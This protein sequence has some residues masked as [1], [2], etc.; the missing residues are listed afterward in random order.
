M[1][2]SGIIKRRQTSTKITT[3][4]SLVSHLSVKWSVSRLVWQKHE[5][6]WHINRVPCKSKECTLQSHRPD[7]HLL[8]HH[9]M[10]LEKNFNDDFFYFWD[11]V[12]TSKRHTQ[13]KIFFFI[14]ILI[15]QILWDIVVFCQ[16]TK[17]RT[18]KSEAKIKFTTMVKAIKR[19]KVVSLLFYFIRLYKLVQ[20][21]GII[22]WNTVLGT[23]KK[24][25]KILNDTEK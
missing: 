20:K 1:F 4:N 9:I 22:Q 16:T 15:F 2:S 14:S 17:G 3:N 7:W 13:K 11:T 12:C 25:E 6:K 19:R 5:K 23:I 24:K 8:N 18:P 21:Q 10:L